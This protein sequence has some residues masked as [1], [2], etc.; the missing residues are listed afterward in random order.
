MHVI[1]RSDANQSCVKLIV[2]SLFRFVL[3]R[4]LDRMEGIVFD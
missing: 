3:M 1:T 2:I 4:Y